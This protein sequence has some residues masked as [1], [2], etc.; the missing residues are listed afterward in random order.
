V[1]ANKEKALAALLTTVTRDEAAAQCGLST[2]TLR[3]YLRDPEFA[4]EYERQR[5][6]LVRDATKQMQSCLQAA[7]STLHLIM[8][9][10]KPVPAARERVVAARSLLEYALR[11]TEVD[12]GAQL[13]AI[14]Q[15]VNEL[16]ERDVIRA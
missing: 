14:E 9:S 16:E 11:Y 10:E 13:A 8:T 4:A 5:R 12:I 3:D 6:E 1:T 15:R 2:R 7:V